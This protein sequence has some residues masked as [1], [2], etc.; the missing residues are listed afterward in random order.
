MLSNDSSCHDELLDMARDGEW[1][2]IDKAESF[3]SLLA[4]DRLS[5]LYLHMRVCVTGSIR[6]ARFHI[7]QY[8]DIPG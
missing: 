3:D 8:L 5:L 6:I 1:S 2:G 4:R 7:R